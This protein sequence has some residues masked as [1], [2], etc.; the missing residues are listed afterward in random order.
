[1]SIPHAHTLTNADPM[2][3]AVLLFANLPRAVLGR[4]TNASWAAWL[5]LLTGPSP[6]RGEGGK[7]SSTHVHRPIHRR[8]G[9]CN[10]ACQPTGQTR[11]DAQG[12]AKPTRK[13]LLGRVDSTHSP[14]IW[15]MH[16]F[17]SISHSLACREE[18]AKSRYLA[19]STKLKIEWHRDIENLHSV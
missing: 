14:V 3:D 10:N 1:M 17:M 9:K 15:T 18:A 4:V 5:E 6:G 19:F 2:L 16:P 8:T 11:P 13:D 12:G 7:Q